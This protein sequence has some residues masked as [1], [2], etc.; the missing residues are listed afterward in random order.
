M[1]KREAIPAGTDRF[2]LAGHGFVLV[3]DFMGQELGLRGADL[4]VYARIF[5]F[6]NAGKVFYETK[7]GTAKFFGLTERAVFDAV[8]RLKARA[9]IEEIPPCEKA[10]RIGSKCYRPVPE[11]LKD[12]GITPSAHEEHADEETSPHEEASGLSLSKHEEPSCQTGFAHEE[13]SCDGLKVV[14]PIP[15]RSN[16]HFE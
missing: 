10:I 4:V 6:Y 16:K 13:R 9:L 7:S 12:I 3:W 15:K 8:K 2:N 14:H 11:I 5:G 1:G